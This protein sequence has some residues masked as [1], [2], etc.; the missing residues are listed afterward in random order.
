MPDEPERIVEGTESSARS[1]VGFADACPFLLLSEASIAALDARLA[2]PVL[3]NRF[4]PNLVV[5]GA[6]P[7]EEDHWS[8]FSIRAVALRAARRCIRCK[9]V[10][11]D[12]E[13]AELGLDPWPALSAHNKH[14]G[15][16]TFGQYLLHEGAGVI[17]RGDTVSF[18]EPV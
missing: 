8:T 18:A 1:L 2:T 11:I 6:E 3:M 16:V 13:K 9:I 12:Q 4:R 10:Q 5:S 14:D 17:R 7:H 15:K